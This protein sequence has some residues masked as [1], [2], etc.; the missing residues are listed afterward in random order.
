LSIQF[1]V[2]LSLPFAYYLNS[3]EQWNLSSK[4]SFIFKSKK[5]FAH[6]SGRGT[7]PTLK[8]TTFEWLNR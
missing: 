8:F 3:F 2:Y 5:F 7:S 4:I 6:Y 1:F